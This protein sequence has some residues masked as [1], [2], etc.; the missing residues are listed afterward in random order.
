[1][2]ARYCFCLLVLMSYAKLT[3]AQTPSSK[4]HVSFGMPIPIKLPL[5]AYVRQPIVKPSPA[6]SLHQLT[7]SRQKVRTVTKL[8]LRPGLP[9][10]T[11]E[12]AELDRR[13]NKIKVF[14]PG[15][16][17]PV[18]I[19]YDNQNRQL[20]ILQPSS[21]FRA[22][23]TLE[24]F[25]PAQK[26]YTYLFQEPDQSSR[27]VMES[28]QQTRGDTTI[29]T[30]RY[31]APIIPGTPVVQTVLRQ[32]RT[33][34]D[35]THFAVIGFDSA[36][37]ALGYEVYVVTKKAG[38]QTSA[39]Q[40]YFTRDLEALLDSSAQARQWRSQGLSDSEILL[41][42][43]GQLRGQLLITNTWT[44]SAKGQLLAKEVLVPEP[45]RTKAV[46]RTTANSTVTMG[47]S[48]G[49]VER[50]FYDKKGCLIREEHKR[51]P[52]ALVVPASQQANTTTVIKSYSP[53]GLLLT[54]TYTKPA[55]A[56]A[57]LPSSSDWH[58]PSD[59]QYEYHYTYY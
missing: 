25:D 37:H 26:H 12:H 45:L 20:E 24:R 40:L 6:D 15:S 33:R 54:E 35:T 28:H 18:R 10:D 59:W 11:L 21:R 55:E 7:L 48:Q 23:Q 8:Q 38:R 17:Q 32:Y 36:H 47:A 52:S 58:S 51:N 34:G 14:M 42:R 19:T 29:T 57:L 16:P 39:G 43:R 53:K 5:M 56:R 9:P 13:G 31:L 1:M 41:R 4:G 49:S 27:L 30:T 2:L 50:Y 44:Y 22:Y 46:T 3:H